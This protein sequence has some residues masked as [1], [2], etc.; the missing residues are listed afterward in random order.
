MIL[1]G[2]GRLMEIEG[3]DE[4]A[5]EGGSPAWAVRWECPGC[6]FRL[7][8]LDAVDRAVRWVDRLVWTDDAR[9]ALDRM[10]PYVS[11]LVKQQAEE[12]ARGT[13][14]R[15]MT[16]AL[17]AQARHG[18]AVAWDLEAERR[19][20]KIPAAVRTMARMELERTALDRGQTMVTVS[21]MEEIKA[22]YFGLSA[23]Q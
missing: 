17:L 11:A 6:R 15:V 9:H 22:R 5:D 8:A 16:V 19:L 18:T 4:Q 1:C 12:F 10:P 21:L 14:Q 2:C 13:G 3:V 7:G 23:S 20:E